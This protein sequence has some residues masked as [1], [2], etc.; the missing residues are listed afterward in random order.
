MIYKLIVNAITSSRMILTVILAYCIITGSYGIL[1]LSVLYL[2]ICMTDLIDGKL[3]RK[4]LAC[5]NF[6]AVLDVLADLFFL[7]TVCITLTAAEMFPVWMLVVMIGKFLEFWYTSSLARRNSENGNHIFL[8]DSLG[9]KVAVMFYILPYIAIL[10][11]AG[12]EDNLALSI[13]KLICIPITT[14]AIISSYLRIRACMEL[15]KVYTA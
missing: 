10:L 1:L 13:M 11:S 4:L 6:G 12:L 9:R 7:M 2:T 5:S 3:A 8:F 15:K 14:G